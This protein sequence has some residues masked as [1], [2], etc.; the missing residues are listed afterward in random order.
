MGSFSAF[1]LSPLCCVKC[2]EISVA[3]MSSLIKRHSICL[4]LSL[5]S[6]WEVLMTRRNNTDILPKSTL[7][8]SLRLCLCL[9]LSISVSSTSPLNLPVRFSTHT[10]S[11]LV[12]YF[13]RCHLSQIPQSSPPQ[14][15][16]RCKVELKKVNRVKKRIWEQ[17]QCRLRRG[18]VEPNH[19]PVVQ[20]LVLS[21]HRNKVLSLNILISLEP[22]CVGLEWVCMCR[23]PLGDPASCH[24]PK[25]C[26]LG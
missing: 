18:H 2:V 26:L 21:P 6:S 16:L 4:F 20:R 22:V 9:Q 11:R 12:H 1:C 13:P 10:A 23:F 3:S 19:K 7:P 5:A 14:V 24:R 15:F 25:T 8:L 17:L